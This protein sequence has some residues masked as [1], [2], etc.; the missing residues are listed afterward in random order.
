MDPPVSHSPPSP[1]WRS[2][3]AP[4]A[5]HDA[6]VGC[7]AF[8]HA[9]CVFAS[10]CLSDDAASHTIPPVAAAIARI[11][12]PER[13]AA[14]DEA[15]RCFDAF[16]VRWR[17]VRASSASLLTALSVTS[18]RLAL[19]CA[20]GSLCTAAAIVRD[21]RVHAGSLWSL[22]SLIASVGADIDPK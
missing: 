22:L 19:L 7:A 3:C 9:T 4:L 5:E 1:S 10:G 6:V 8:V 16:G 17:A 21:P 15:N 12:S 14:A 13:G 18:P 20:Q 2:I 11:D